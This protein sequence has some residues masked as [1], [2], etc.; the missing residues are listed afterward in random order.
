MPGSEPI[1]VVYAKE[2]KEYV[3]LPAVYVDN[4]NSRTV[5]SR[6]RLDD[7]ERASVAAGADVVMQLLMPRGAFL[8]PSN[9]QIVMPD[10][11]PVLIEGF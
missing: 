7:A 1:E 8:T 3:P 5:V 6:W 9:L 4:A 2:Q 11:A 10:E